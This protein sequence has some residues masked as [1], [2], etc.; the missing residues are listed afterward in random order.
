MVHT[1]NEANPVKRNRTNI[2]LD[3][4]QQLLLKHLAAEQGRSLSD[5]VRQAVSAFWVPRA[6]RDK[7]WS[8]HFRDLIDRV[9]AKMP[10]DLT[11]EEVDAD[12]AEVHAKVRERSVRL[13]EIRKS[14]AAAIDEADRGLGRPL[15]VEAVVDEIVA[16]RAALREKRRAR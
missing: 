8:R 9:Q 14:V 10:P 7:K 5:L 2:Y 4:A 1:G 13:E 16:R 3:D 6:R 11:P 15:D 12:I